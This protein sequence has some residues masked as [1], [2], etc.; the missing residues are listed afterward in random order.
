MG[1]GSLR[2]SSKLNLCNA[3][4]L[5]F[6]VICTEEEGDVPE[7]FGSLDLF[8]ETCCFH[9]VDD[10]LLGFSL[11]DKVSVCTRRRDES[12]EDQRPITGE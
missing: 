4:F 1:G 11:T 8:D 9:L 7:S 3:D 12:N 5:R 10:L 2:I 6:L